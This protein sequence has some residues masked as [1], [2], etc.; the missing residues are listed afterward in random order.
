MHR[1]QAPGEL[2]TI[3]G[4]RGLD[5]FLLRAL[6]ESSKEAVVSS[7]MESLEHEFAAVYVAQDHT[8]DCGVAMLIM[9]MR[10]SRRERCLRLD[11]FYQREAALWTID[12]FDSLMES[13]VL[14]DC[15][16]YTNCTEVSHHHQLEFYQPN[17]HE[18]EQRVTALLQKSVRLH[19]NLSKASYHVI[20]HR[21]THLCAGVTG[22]GRH[23]GS[24]LGP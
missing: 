16:F 23:R 7:L 20:H 3:I 9:V 12:I 15:E 10:W 6:W 13:R 18:D 1:L 5:M 11:R 22:L 17:M 4:R 2:L 21:P 8:W 19:W 14:K 24:S